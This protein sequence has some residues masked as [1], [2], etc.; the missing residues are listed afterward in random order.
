MKKGAFITGTDTGVGKTYFTAFWTLS[1]KKAGVQA[2]PLKPISTGDRSDAKILRQSVNSSL[3]LHEINPVH[4]EPPLAPWAACRA[5]GRIFPLEKLRNHLAGLRSKYPGPFLIEGVGG[6]RV[7][8]DRNYGVREWARE[9]GYPVV[10]VARAGLGT[11]NHI[12]LSVDSILRSKLK[13]SGI[14]VNLHQ[15]RDDEATRS[16]PK[17][18]EELTG[19]PV[20]TLASGATPSDKL[21]SWLRIRG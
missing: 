2:F 21:P 19:L 1:L 9:M 15:A 3:S 18:I 16:N 13:V 10:V 6:W 4:F 12:L 5:M 14:V 8:L 7:P 20:F 17:L 11:L